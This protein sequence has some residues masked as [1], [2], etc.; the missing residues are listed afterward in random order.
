MS[1]KLSLTAE[2]SFRVRGLRAGRYS[3]ARGW[4]E[5][6]N[7][8]FRTREFD[9][10]VGEEKELALGDALGPYSLS[11]H[12]ADSEGSPV[13][14][15]DLTLRP[16]FSWDYTVFRV[17]SATGTYH[18]EGL[19]PGR[20]EVKVIR[21]SASGFEVTRHAESIEIASDFR[22]DFILSAVAE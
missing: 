10:G 1:R 12:I 21:Y 16:E 14:K 13:A 8:L 9:L 4:R 7:R 17:Y 22:R 2:G 6:E 5:G 11:G 3:L 15:S 19:R 18:V 20:Y